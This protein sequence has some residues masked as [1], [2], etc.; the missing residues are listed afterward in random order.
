MSDDPFCV[1]CG[2]RLS[3]HPDPTREDDEN[4]DVAIRKAEQLDRFWTPFQ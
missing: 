1:Y 2:V 4:C 3:L